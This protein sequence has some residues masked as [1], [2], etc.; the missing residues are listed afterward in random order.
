MESNLLIWLPVNSPDAYNSV[1]HTN[2]W[3]IQHALQGWY[4]DMNVVGDIL[5]LTHFPE[6]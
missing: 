1:Y 4:P 5:Q 6:R 3:Q 2:D